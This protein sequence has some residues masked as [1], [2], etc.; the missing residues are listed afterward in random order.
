MSEE[1]SLGSLPNTLSEEKLFKKIEERKEALPSV[2]SYLSETAYQFFDLQI[3][4]DRIIMKPLADSLTA[5]E[6]STA[7]LK[8][9]KM[10]IEETLSQC[11]PQIEKTDPQKGDIPEELV[12]PS[13]EEQKKLLYTIFLKER[14]M[15]Q[16]I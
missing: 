7:D 1:I 14:S 13:Q 8:N 11:K 12:F 6:V 10:A 16:K 15:I 2:V 4:K 3:E 9:V 5:I